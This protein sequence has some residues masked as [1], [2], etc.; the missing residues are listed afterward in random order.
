MAGGDGAI[1]KVTKAGEVTE[2]PVPTAGDPTEIAVGPDNNLWSTDP[3]AN[4]VSR[5]T[6]NG[7]VT[8]FHPSASYLKG[9]TARHPG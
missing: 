1:A 6:P 7:G 8:E 4:L 2:Y 3:A 9:F 5:I